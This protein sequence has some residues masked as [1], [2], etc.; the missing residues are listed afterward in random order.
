MCKWS[1]RARSGCDCVLKMCC[2]NEV[3]K[4][5]SD[6]GTSRKNSTIMELACHCT[7]HE[8]HQRISICHGNF[9]EAE[10]ISELESSIPQFSHHKRFFSV[11]NFSEFLDE[12]SSLGERPENPHFDIS[13]LLRSLIMSSHV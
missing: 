6:Y 12:E 4:L 8:R 10:I 9:W 7:P 11:Q 2:S 5:E 13:K 3:Y 1:R